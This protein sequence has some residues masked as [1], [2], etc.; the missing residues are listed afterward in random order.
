MKTL[1]LAFALSLTAQAATLD[2]VL[3]GY[4][5]VA[6]ALAKDDFAD[7]AAKA[8]KLAVPAAE[9]AQSGGALSKHYDKVASGARAMA[10]STK[11][12]DLRSKMTVLSDGAVWLVKLTPALQSKWQLYKCPMVGGGAFQFW[13]QPVGDPMANPYM[14]Q[15]MLQCGVRRT[16]AKFP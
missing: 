9:L 1:V 5:D 2:D 8:A 13:M 10:A 12:V 4:R 6:T 16:W 11:E 15:E 14:G 3:S 7:T